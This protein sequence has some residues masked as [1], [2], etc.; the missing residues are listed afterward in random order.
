MLA[1]LE[2][3]QRSSSTEFLTLYP[4]ITSRLWGPCLGPVGVEGTSPHWR[5]NI[6]ERLA[7]SGDTRGE[8]TLTIKSATWVMA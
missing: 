8:P 3:F 1:S 7:G 4:P 2:D 6:A 5:P